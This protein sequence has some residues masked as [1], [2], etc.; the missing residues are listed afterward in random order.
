MSRYVQS[1]TLSEILQ[2]RAAEQPHRQFLHFEDTSFTYLECLHRARGVASA[3]QFH[4]VGRGQRV[5]TMVTNGINAIDLWFGCSIAGAVEVPINIELKSNLLID[6]VSRAHCELLIVEESFLEVLVP[7]REHLPP[8]LT[9]TAFLDHAE[10]PVEQN[11]G[12][13][14]ETSVILF[15]SGTSGP[16][17]GVVLNHRANFR[18]ANAMIDNT[19][20][21]EHDVLYT[22]FPLFHVAARYVSVLAAMI[23]DG[24]VVVHKKFSASQFWDICDSNGVTAIHYLGTVP[25]MLWNQPSRTRDSETTVRLA[26]GAGMPGEVWEGFE[27]RFNLKV[28]ELYGSTEQGA[29]TM[30]NPENRRVGT[31]G[32]VVEDTELEIHD[33]LGFKVSTNSVGEI[34]V[35]NR[36]SGIFFAGYL[37]MPDATVQSWRNLWFHT[38][39]AG[40]LDEDGYLTFVGRIKDSIRRRGENI[41]AWELERILDAFPAIAESAAMGVPS[42]IGE[43]EILVC[44]V[45][46]HNETIDPST[47]WRYC[48]EHL[49]RYAIPRYLRIV[50][51]LPKTATDKIE[52]YKI[53]ILTPDTFDRTKF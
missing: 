19:K 50:E 7:L 30:T 3:L 35:R 8:I 1:E 5:A 47:V 46:E 28:F 17:K 20:L 44:V 18:L 2:Y 33:Q 53:S 42:E 4:G 11:N 37:D 38:G 39:D 43:E 48:E 27:N 22:T 45:P 9:T 13:P 12:A 24:S 51:S 49:P 40:R 52:K 31:C 34:V 21:T 29:V 16:S 15:T 26:Y 41:S 6:I 32:Q 23:I 14:E 25:M 36:V 10:K